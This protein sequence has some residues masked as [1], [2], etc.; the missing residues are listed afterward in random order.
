MTLK[1]GEAAGRLTRSWRAWTAPG[2][3]ILLYHRVAETPSPWYQLSV[4]SARFLEH[5]EVLRRLAYPISLGALA[6]RLRQGR[7][8]RK[9]VALTFDDGYADNLRVAKPLLE[10]HAVPATVF[11]TS[12]LVGS[13]EGFWWDE[14]ERHVF[15]APRLPERVRV[16]TDGQVHEF[17]LPTYGDGDAGGARRHLVAA[18]DRLM[19]RASPERRREILAQLR[20]QVPADTTLGA[21]RVLTA[22][23][24]VRLA[25]GDLIEVGAHTV[26]HPVLSGLSPAVQRAE[27]AGSKRA[28]E[29]MLGRPVVAFSYPFGTT[30]DFDGDS[31]AIAREAGFVCACTVLPRAVRSG[32]D[33]YRLP[34]FAVRDWDGDMLA[35][36]LRAWW[37]C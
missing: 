32:A 1:V 3:L 25:D 22:D 30:D 26:T 13:S 11:V 28:L 33:A 27:V 20:A 21:D 15:G 8:P 18:L 7:V 10:R 31:V 2:A 29:A 17:G 6:A 12:G 23:E 4:T 35:R 9:A 37:G 5:L 24:L 19:R 16:V 14:L 36:R 34:R